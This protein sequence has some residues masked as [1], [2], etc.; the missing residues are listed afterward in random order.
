MALEVLE[1]ATTASAELYPEIGSSYP[2]SASVSAYSDAG[3]ELAT[4][5]AVVDSVSTTLSAVSGTSYQTITLAS[6]AG[7]KIGRRYRLENAAGEVAVVMVSSIAG[8]VVTLRDPPG[9]L[10]APASG[11]SFRGIRV[12]WTLPAAATA[13]RG[14]NNRILWT[15]TDSDSVVSAYTSIYHVVKT[16]FRDPV[17]PDAVYQYV[18]RLH[19][20]AAASMTPARREEVADRANRR[21]RAR[22]LET[23]RRP[24]LIGDA[25]AFKEAGRVA[26]QWVLLDDRHVLINSDDDLLDQLTAL[27]NRL[28]VE[29]ARA[30]D[31]MTWHDTDDDQAVD[32]GEIAPVS[33]RILL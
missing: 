12:Y 22:L 1:D 10:T 25:D 14:T 19:P 9:F 6:A 7:V 20:G 26:L 21:V 17:T 28:A 2:S 3:T 15:V 31:A 32:D 18:A 29:V 23:Q 24:H 13:D 16:L 33:A 4:A 27:D 5:S 8:S 11:D 30:I